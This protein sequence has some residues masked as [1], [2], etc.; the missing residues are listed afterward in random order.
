MLSG[1]SLARLIRQ[2]PP[3]PSP[4]DGYPTTS[5]QSPRGHHWATLTIGGHVPVGA[6]RSGS[7]LDLNFSL[8][9]Q[10][11]SDLLLQQGVRTLQ[12][13][14]LH[15]QLPEPQL[16]LLL[17]RALQGRTEPAFAP[18]FARGRRAASSIRAPGVGGQGQG[19]GSGRTPPSG[20]GS[21][22]LRPAHRGRE[23]SRAGAVQPNG[24]IPLTWP[25]LQAP[26]A[27]GPPRPPSGCRDTCCWLSAHF[28]GHSS[29]LL[30]KLS[31]L[32]LAPSQASSCSFSSLS[33]DNLTHAKFQPSPPH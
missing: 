28:P 5:S 23:E 19:P 26:P 22:R 4:A 16:R 33:I 3:R 10:R 31:L 25:K 8:G 12:G 9:V 13:L 30:R 24:Q 11:P 2:V 21:R 7:Q 20:A 32:S 14:V 18:A 1:G 15:G 17:G 27:Q 6:Q 29:G